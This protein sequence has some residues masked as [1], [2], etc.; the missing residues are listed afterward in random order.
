MREREEEGKK[1]DKEEEEVG[2]V[3]RGRRR[4]RQPGLNS[5]YENLVV[6]ITRPEGPPLTVRCYCPS[7]HRAQ[8]AGG[9]ADGE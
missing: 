7:V 2:M 6:H 3:W 1:E 5:F 8:Q 9:P 4:R